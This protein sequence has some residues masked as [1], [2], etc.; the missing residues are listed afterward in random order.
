M[1]KFLSNRVSFA[2]F[3]IITLLIAY[4]IV[5][6][7]VFVADY[8]GVEH[9][10]GWALGVARSLAERGTY[11]SLTS[12]VV[13]PTLT[14]GLNREGQVTIQDGE[15]REYFFIGNTMGPGVVLPSALI[16]KLFG[17]G[18]WQSRV[19]G[20]IFFALFLILAS[21]ILYTIGG[22]VSVIIFH[23]YLLFF[24]QLYV[25]LGYEAL[26]E[27][28]SMVYIFLSFLLFIK[29]VAVEKRRGLWYLASGLLVGVAINTRFA[30]MIVFGGMPLIWLIAYRQQRAKLKEGLAFLS[31]II[32][33]GG[34]WQLYVFIGLSRIA[35]S[36]AYFEHLW[37]QF[38][39]LARTAQG[40][41]PIAEGWELFLLKA[42]ILSEIS[43]SSLWLSLALAVITLTGTLWLLRQVWPEPTQRYWVILLGT[44]WLIYTLWFLSGPKNA[45]VRYYWFGLIWMVML[46]ALIVAALIRQ[47][48]QSGQWTNWAG[49]ILLAGLMGVSFSSQPQAISLFINPDLV[50]LWRQRQL[51]TP[52]TYLPWII[53]P[54]AEQMQAADFIRTLP[55]EATIYYPEGH[56][57]A[58]LSFLT[59]RIFYTLPRRGRVGPQ[60][61]DV[62]IIGPA[63]TSSWKKERQQ[64]QDILETVYRECPQIIFESPNYIVCAIGL[65]E[66]G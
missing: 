28:P 5:R 65:A 6:L 34:A 3:L 54:R 57:T 38:D 4:Q 60:P 19:G 37:G 48:R 18:F 21:F 47:A 33:I 43:Y 7:V 59:N 36:G 32:I 23:L 31:G 35:G 62:L 9:D 58:E 49:A 16:F 12:T 63:L 22:L 17:V 44:A 40:I 50:E 27:M 11:T 64:Q 55:P 15:G 51:S 1:S 39:F 2:A 45:W 42:I 14:I 29:A 26:G 52:D 20:L 10:G 25:F 13:D 66:Q 46:L 61:D 53:V 41:T 24:P 56:K 8:G 30:T